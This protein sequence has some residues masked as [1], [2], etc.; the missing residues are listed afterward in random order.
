MKLRGTKD[1]LGCAEFVDR[2]TS[3]ADAHPGL[4]GDG[5]VGHFDDAVV[6]RVV[7]EDLEDRGY[8]ESKSL[9]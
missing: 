2:P 4:L 9:A 3:R 6:V 1:P 7:A 8:R 5:L